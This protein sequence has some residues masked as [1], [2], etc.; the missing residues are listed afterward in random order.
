[1][2]L[3]L[4]KMIVWNTCTSRKKNKYFAAH[5]SFKL[6]KA[7]LSTYFHLINCQSI[8]LYIWK[9]FFNSPPPLLFN[10]EIIHWI[11]VDYSCRL[12][13]Y[14]SRLCNGMLWF[15]PKGNKRE[16]INCIKSIEYLKCFSLGG[17]GDILGTFKTRTWYRAF[18]IRL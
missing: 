12:V 7:F 11:M 4:F 9:G 17:R 6:Y 18:S 8:C 13:E 2:N 1:M 10:L 16:I 15:F 5:L 14:D 3:I